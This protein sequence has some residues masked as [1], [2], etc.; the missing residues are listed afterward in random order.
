MMQQSA[1]MRALLALLALFG[2]AVVPSP[3]A[4]QT[5]PT[6]FA[7]A[8][9]RDAT[10]ASTAPTSTFLL[11]LGELI[12]RYRADNGLEPLTFAD[13]LATLAGEHSASMAAQRHLS[14][15]GFRD[16]YRV[17][18]SKICVENVAWNY[19]TPESLLDGWRQ[20]PAHHR[21]LLEPKVMRMGLAATTRYVTFFACR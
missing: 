11:Q 20:S 10:A 15:D 19:P 2:A 12:N 14:H 9:L 1:R 16:R 5:A 4:A 3:A 13:D 6:L 7:L 21:N 8:T 18:S 17:A